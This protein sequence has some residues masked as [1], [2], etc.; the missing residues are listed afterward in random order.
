MAKIGVPRDA[1]IGLFE[2]GLISP[3]LTAHPTEVRRR[4]IIERETA[5]A[6]LAAQVETAL[7]QEVEALEDQLRAEI[8]GCGRRASYARMRINVQDEIDNIIAT[9]ARTFLPVIPQLY[10]AWEKLLQVDRLPPAL[11]LGSWIG[12]D[13]DGHPLVTA[14]VLIHAFDHQVQFI[15]DHYLQELHR[16]GGELSTCVTLVPVTEELRVLAD[17]SGDCSDHRRDEPYRRALTL[18]YARLSATRLRLVGK[19]PA[20]LPRLAAPAYADV[21]EFLAD[22][23]IVDAS[24]R[25]DRGARLADGRLGA[26]IRA[27]TCFGF[28][29]FTVDLRQNAEVHERVVAELLAKAGAPSNYLEMEEAERCEVLCAE[30]S[31]ERLLHSRFLT[32]GEETTSEL[33]IVREAAKVHQ[34]LGSAAIA[35]Y[36]ISKASSASDILEVFVLLKEV[37]LFAGGAAPRSALMVSPLFESIDDLRRADQIMSDFLALPIANSIVKAQGFVQE[38]MLG[39]SD[40][41]K[42]GGYLTS[43]WELRQAT[44]RLVALYASKGIKPQ[45][46]HGRGGAVGRGGGSNIDAI[47]GQPN[48]S[49]EGRIRVTEQGSSKAN[50]ARRNFAGT[51]STRLSLRPCRRRFCRVPTRKGSTRSSRR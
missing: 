4:C 31:H 21:A 44:E 18:I 29:L 1:V 43:V 26:L 15:L 2:Q 6:A 35:N 32:Y 39:Y 17:A 48:H 19:P 25:A 45:L 47:L 33:A 38:V 11:R 50:M 37:G 10:R 41:N 46:F 5:V 30:L 8:T 22:L 23:D 28:H 27:A 42:D 7:P 9:F 20:R 36:V 24:L 12:G 51:T 34:K 13:R 14:Q 16:L 3:V 49:V 40:S